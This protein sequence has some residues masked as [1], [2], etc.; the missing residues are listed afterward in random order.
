M[1][2]LKVMLAMQDDNFQKILEND[3][4]I[5]ELEKEKLSTQSEYMQLM[6]MFSGEIDIAGIRCN[7]LTLGMWCFLYS[8]KN[9]FTR[10]QQI[11]K[12]D[13]DVMLYLLH[14]GYNG[15]SEDLFE[16]SLNFC[17]NNNINY[18]V[19]LSTIHELIHISFRPLELLPFAQGNNDTGFNLEWLTSIVSIVCR[20]C[21]CT[22]EFV[23][24]KMSMCEAF[25]Y[26][27]QNLKENDVKNQ[28]QRRNNIEIDSL[29]Y[30]RTM[31]LGQ[32]YYNDNYK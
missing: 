14:N 11:T 15:V 30:K 2:D 10:A 32:K 6:Y 25:Y 1:I 21:N 31:E 23:L 8:I 9:A 4:I 5:N 24:Y 20:M 19:A 3:E 16:N 27:I 17:E 28:I 12:T 22:R 7:V 26:V 18:D 29:I 13:V